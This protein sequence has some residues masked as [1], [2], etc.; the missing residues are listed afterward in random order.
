[1]LQKFHPALSL[2]PDRNE[3]LLTGPPFDD[4]TSSSSSRTLQM[5]SSAFHD[6][7]D[8]WIAKR[9]VCPKGAFLHRTLELPLKTFDQP[10]DFK[11]NT[12]IDKIVEMTTGVFERQSVGIG[13]I[14]GN[15]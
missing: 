5:S 12:G 10:V 13:K 6:S 2:Q 1:M 3:V 8:S 15:L 7:P 9:L 4:E 11:M 14:R